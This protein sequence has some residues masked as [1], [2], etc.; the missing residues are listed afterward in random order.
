MCVYVC[1][2]RYT[3][4]LFALAHDSVAGVRQEVVKGMVQLLT[5]QPAKLQPYLYQ[6]STSAAQSVLLGGRAKGPLRYRPSH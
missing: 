3:L 4:S 6:V 5:I 1:V 2:C